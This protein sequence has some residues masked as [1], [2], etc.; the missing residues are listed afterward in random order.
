MR[1]RFLLLCLFTLNLAVLQ[2]AQEFNGDTPSSELDKLVDSIG[3]SFLQGEYNKLGYKETKIDGEKQVDEVPTSI[4]ILKIAG[5]IGRRMLEVD[6]ALRKLKEA[7][8]E[9]QLSSANVPQD[10]CVDGDYQESIRFR[11]QVKLVD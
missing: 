5:K 10:C 9:D 8:E 1:G 4:I 3:W 11:T 6:N 7:V 2:N